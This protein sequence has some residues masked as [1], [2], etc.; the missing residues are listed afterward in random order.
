MLLNEWKHTQNDVHCIIANNCTDVKTRWADQ[1]FPFT[2]PSW[3]LEVECDGEW[4]EVVGC[5]II[6][7]ELLN[8]GKL[9]YFVKIPIFLSIHLSPM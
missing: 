6:Q 1:H 5:G 2:H 3:E 7:Q 9:L 8:R 4:L